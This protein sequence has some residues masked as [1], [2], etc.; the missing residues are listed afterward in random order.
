MK[1]I[2]IL[3]I[4]AMLL[5]VS[6]WG[7]GAAG[8]GTDKTAD[9]KSTETVLKHKVENKNA[10]VGYYTRDVSAR[11][12]LKVYKALNQRVTGKVGIKV[13]FGGDNEQ[14]LD[15]KLMTELAKET[16]GT[17]L[18]ACGYTP[19]RDDPPGTYS[20]AERHGF[21]A[22]APVDIIDRDGD[23]DMPV[24]GGYHLKYARTGAHLKN[25]DTLIAVHRF[26]AH[27]LPR[28][29]GNMKNISLCLGSLSGK[30]IIHSAGTN[31]NSYE[32]KD[33]DI[34]SQSFA[35]AAKAAMDYKRG[36]WAFINVMDKFEP[37]DSCKDTKN[38]GDIGIIASL[39]PVAV[40]QASCDF[41]FGAAP[42]EEI[43]NAW[44]KT[45]SVDLLE[46]AEKIGVGSRHYQ[47]V[48]VD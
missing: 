4:A 12:L 39:D 34:T 9:A 47:L 19:P 42:S 18:D 36:R 40:D 38:L 27:Y 21:A 20:A 28:F 43:R 46:Y 17:F 45:H 7:H 37:S 15:P 30:A 35:D 11:G 24:R 5:I 1:K 41:E 33:D 8:G 48:S 16:K 13:S 32:R 26:K 3:G 31:E 25:Y 14:Y 6:V 22:V 2:A 44:E 23:V 10:P 29:G